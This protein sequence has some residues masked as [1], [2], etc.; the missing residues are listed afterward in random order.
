MGRHKALR[1]MNPQQKAICKEL[2][3]KSI[4]HGFNCRYPLAPIAEK[5]GIREELY[6]NKT[7][8]G[9]IWELGAHGQGLLDIHPNG[10]SAGI[11]WENHETV[12]HWCT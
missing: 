2:L 10:E 9:L 12:E 7:H 3:Q 8:S 5:L 6:N 4:H 1:N 11:E